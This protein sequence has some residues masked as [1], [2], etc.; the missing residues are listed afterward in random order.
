MFMDGHVMGLGNRSPFDDDPEIC[1]PRFPELPDELLED[2]HYYH[3]F[4]S[5]DINVWRDQVTTMQVLPAGPDR[6]LERY[7]IYLIGNAATKLSEGC[8]SPGRKAVPPAWSPA[9]GVSAALHATDAIFFWRPA[10]SCWGE[11][12]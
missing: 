4:P 5:L 8:A 6:T 11:R 9:P 10:R 3:L 2:G 1:L 7:D 12:S